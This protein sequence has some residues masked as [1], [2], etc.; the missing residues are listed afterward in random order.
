MA[1]DLLI[2][3]ATYFEVSNYRTFALSKGIRN[4]QQHQ[5]NEV[6]HYN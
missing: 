4:S 1:S 2:L 6:L 5:V 3:S